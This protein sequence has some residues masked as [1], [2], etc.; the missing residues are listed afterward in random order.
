MSK[1]FSGRETL[2]SLVHLPNATS[3][4]PKRP[5]IP[6]GS[7]MCAGH[8]HQAM[9]CYF[10][11]CISREQTCFHRKC[12][13]FLT[14]CYYTG[15]LCFIY[16]ILNVYLSSLVLSLE[17]EKRCWKPR[18]D[19]ELYQKWNKISGNTE[20]HLLALTHFTELSH[21]IQIEVSHWNKCLKPLKPVN[22]VS[23]LNIISLNC[24]NVF[25]LVLVWSLFS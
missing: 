21:W 2:H 15:P 12:C 4:K 8:V 11:W 7:P 10:L 22:L 20:C 18:L 24:A 16:G 5:R 1:T 14:L 13:G 23:Q 19:H 9:L 3:Q 6:A 17:I 25:L